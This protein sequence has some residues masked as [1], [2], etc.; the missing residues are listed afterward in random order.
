MHHI[1]LNVH[2]KH[3]VQTFN[4]NL[5]SSSLLSVL[6][7]I[8]AKGPFID[9]VEVKSCVISPLSDPKKSRFWTVISDGCSS[10]PSLTLGAKTQDEEEEEDEGDDDELEE[11]KEE[12]DGPEE[13]RDGDVPLR[14]K[15]ERRGSERAPEIMEKNTTDVGAEVEIQPLR[16]SFILRPV[17]NDSMQFLHC[18]LRLCISDL[19][20]GEPTKETVKNDCQGG[21]RIPPLVS[22]STRHQVQKQLAHKPIYFI[23]N[24]RTKTNV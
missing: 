5:S 7:Q 15:V 19:K 21:L 10:D 11:E 14:H 22:R 17:Y 3:L 2:I 18:S 1:P 4:C 9:V 12:I 8:S 24:I 23:L 16:F 13:G 6:L 20:R